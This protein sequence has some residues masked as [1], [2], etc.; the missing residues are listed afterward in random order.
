MTIKTV[1]TSAAI[2]LCYSNIAAAKD[3]PNL[4]KTHNQSETIKFNSK[5]AKNLTTIDSPSTATTITK[6]GKQLRNGSILIP[7]EVAQAVES[8]PSTESQPT[9]EKLEPSANPLQFPTQPEEVQINTEKPITLQQAIELAIKNNQDLQESQLNLERS[10]EELQEARAALY[11][12]L[13]T[14]ID[15][16]RSQS[17]SSERSLDLANQRGSSLI[18]EETTTE[19][20][21]GTLSLSY[22]IYTGGRRGADIERAKRQV[23]FNELDLER[24]TFEVRFETAR[25][26]YNLQNADAQVEIEQAAVEDAQQ[27]LRDAQLLEQAGL[28]TRFDVLRAEVELA[29]AQQRLTRAEADQNT[30][31]RQLAETL[32]VEQQVELRTADEIKP[33]GDWELSLEETIVLAYKNRAELEQFL[34]RREIN[35]QQRQIALSTIRPQVSVFANYDVLDIADDNVDPTDGYTIGTRLQWSLF[36]G[37]AA[38][39]RAR[40]SETDIQ[41]DETQ[42]A[43]QRNQI[44]FQVEQGYYNLT[45]SKEN[46]ATSEKA[47]QLAEESL[48]LARLRFQAGVGTQTDVIQAQSE[49]TT[50]RG[51]YLRA[52]IDYNQSLNQLE[53]AVTNLPEGKLFDLPF[54]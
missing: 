43:N 14:Q 41:I 8:Q 24:I 23:R 54:N 31:R 16:S 17:A 3:L 20:V 11:P 40:Q 10:Q 22:N 50:A 38:T 47:V 2:L 15:L 35:E 12:T 46:I 37:G 27:T 39:A 18:D 9:V 25:D 49:L 53:R 30:S 7:L 29:N 34:V 4:S 33:A 19:S 48:R 45:S 21:N 42:F 6:K 44:R 36:D 32:S 28:G 1:V 52:I 13:D 26:Y 51:N 5:Q